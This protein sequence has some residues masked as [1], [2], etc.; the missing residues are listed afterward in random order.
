MKRITNYL[1][2]RKRSDLDVDNVDANSVQT[3]SLNI[4]DEY[5]FPEEKGNVGDIL[6][7]QATGDLLVA[8]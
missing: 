1:G 6:V 8:R 3:K 2:K 4:T 7:Q 5:N